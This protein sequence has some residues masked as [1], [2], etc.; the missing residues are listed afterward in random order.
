M[1]MVGDVVP[2]GAIYIDV[3]GDGDGVEIKNEIVKDEADDPRW[4]CVRCN[5]V[6]ISEDEFNMLGGALEM[7]NFCT[8][9]WA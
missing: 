7:H 1:A 8:M 4:M 5:H 2:P 9:C 6:I 3:T